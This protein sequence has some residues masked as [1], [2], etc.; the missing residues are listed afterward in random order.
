[1]KIRSPIVTLVGHVDHGKSSILDFIRGSNIVSQEAGGITQSLKSYSLPL[2][3]INKIAGNLISKLNIQVTIPGML[4]LDSPG[5]AAFTNLRRRGGNLADIAILVI[6]IKEGIMPQTAES[7]EILRSYKTPFIIALNKI[8]SLPSWRSNPE[9]PLI[10]N[11]QSQQEQVIQQIETKLYNIVGKLSELS[12]SAERFDRIDDYTKQIAIIPCS[13]KTGEGVPELLMVLTGLAQKYLESSLKIEIA[14]PGKGTIL[15]VRE[16]RG[17]GKVLDIIL[18]DGT[19]RQNDQI[20]IATLAEPIITKIRTLFEQDGGKLKQAKEVVAASG[21]IISAPEL[22]GAISGMPLQAVRNSQ[23]ET[24]EELEKE[25]QEVLIETEKEGIIIKADSLGSL[26]ALINLLKEKDIP[27]KR[28]TIGDINKKN[29]AEAKSEK[30]QENRVILGFNIKQLHSDEVKII[31]SNV[32]YKIIEEYD[33]WLQEIK[34]Q[35]ELKELSS[36]IY[37]AKMQI[38]RGTVFRQS[39]PAVVG[40]RV[41]TG[42]LH[43]NTPLIRQDNVK[44]GEVKSMQSEGEFLQEAKKSQEVAISIPG[45]TVGRQIDEDMILYA[46]VPEKDFIKLKKLKSF[47]NSDEVELLKE[48]AVIK[49]KSEPMWGV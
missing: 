3:Q 4:F 22:D 23:Q 20:A 8:D 34:K 1:M 9:N 11:I 7:I 47:L 30:K 33:L 18:Y 31:T 38:L 44:I 42:K 27:I 40:I 15:E 2:K 10:K 14:G 36:V 45:A 12:L 35:E 5:H 43:T 17:L 28:A 46:D 6:D 19:L 49:R 37:P 26:E 24:I 29:I 39:N 16:E 25:I 41:I 13:A 48:M 21:I 32:I